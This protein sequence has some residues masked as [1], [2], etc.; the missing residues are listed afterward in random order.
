MCMYAADSCR[1]GMQMKDKK[2]FIK[3]TAQIVATP[4]LLGV[5]G[6]LLLMAAFSLP[7]QAIREHVHDSLDE[8][9]E[10]GNYYDFVFRD[11]CS[12]LDNYTEA[13]YLNQA[14]VGTDIDS[15]LVCALSGYTL[16]VTADDPIPTLTSVFDN[17]EHTETSTVY[18][19]FFNGYDVAVRPLLMLT[20][21]QGIRHINLYLMLFVS[22]LLCLLMGRRNLGDYILPLVVSVLF[23]HP[24]VIAFNMTFMGFYL[25]MTVPCI[26]FLLLPEEELRKKAPVLFAAIGAIT[27]YFNMNYFQLLCFA[28]PFMIYVLLLGVPQKMKE[29]AQ[30]FV[31]TFIPW[32]IGYCGM[33]VFKWIL[34]AVLV[35]TSIF[36]DMLNRILLRTGLDEGSRIYAVKENIRTALTNKKWLMM[37]IA[38]GFYSVAMWWKNKENLHIS[39]SSILLLLSMLLVPILRYALFS[40]HVIIHHWFMYRILMMPILAFNLLI[41]EAWH[42]NKAVR[43]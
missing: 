18:K 17:W 8:L 39:V 16:F 37:E 19:R 10:E 12:R 35:D 13:I 41:T 3:L 29:A 32:L 7:S 33:M 43:L 38:F 2:Q 9:T 26:V 22:L 20:D 30:L 36:T 24:L 23:I 28:M 42:E 1:E 21:Y 27:F 34:Y 6:V 11:K 5:L 15:A 31:S 4:I 40:N 14:L 25:C